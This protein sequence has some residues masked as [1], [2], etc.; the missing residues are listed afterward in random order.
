MKPRAIVRLKGA[1]RLMAVV[2]VERN[3]DG[4]EERMVECVW[5]SHGQPVRGKFPV[6][7]LEVAT[8][9]ML[10]ARLTRIRE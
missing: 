5:F 3:N 1:V 7:S 6:D 10:A 4:N 9:P 8:V 2:S